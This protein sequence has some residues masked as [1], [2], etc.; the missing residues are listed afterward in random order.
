VQGQ[1]ALALDAALRAWEL[2]HEE[3]VAL[4]ALDLAEAER[5]PK[6]ALKLAMRFLTE[7]AS[8]RE[9]VLRAAA[10]H[11]AAGD[12][13]QCFALLDRSFLTEDPQLGT[14]AQDLR[15]SCLAEISH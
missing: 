15:R 7:R 14:A 8:T 4:L 10:L 6:Q 2:G 11:R 5:G 12:P 13:R 1:N 9:V 3:A